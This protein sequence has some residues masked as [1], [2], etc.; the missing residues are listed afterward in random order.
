MQTCA[1]IARRPVCWIGFFV[2]PLLLTFMFTNLMEVGLPTR[3]PAAIVDMDHTTMSRDLTQTLNGMQMVHI[4]KATESYT[5]ARRDMQQGEIFGYFL[6]PRNFEQDLLSGRRPV[7][8]FYTNMAY[9]VPANLLYKNFKLAAVYTKAEVVQSVLSNTGM[10]REQMSGMLSP[11]NIVTRPLN[12]PELNYPIYLTNSFLPCCF[13]LLIMMMTCYLICNDIKYGFSRYYLVRAGGSILR[14][15]CAKLLPVFIIWLVEIMFM[16]SM[17]FFW[18]GYP[19]NGSHL[20]MILSEVLFVLA[21]MSLGLLF[22]CIIPNM[23]LALSNCAL[24]G[25]LSFSLAAFSF[26]VEN[27]YGGIGIF[28]YI[29]PTR[30]NF[31]IYIDQALNGIDIYYSRWWFVAYIIFIVLPLPFLARLKRAMAKPVYAP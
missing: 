7:I 12:N 31:L 18:C 17:L 20:W 28:S 10:S 22:A 24:I 1:E 19:M 30:Y 23:R 4:T 25:I 8:T 9:Y 27:M 29:L 13:Q 5:E 6:I 2:L 14:E 15:L 26:P 21:S 3:I 16:Y 11:V